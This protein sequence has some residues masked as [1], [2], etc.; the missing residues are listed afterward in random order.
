MVYLIVQNIPELGILSL[1]ENKKN[2]PECHYVLQ[3]V[4]RLFHRKKRSPYAVRPVGAVTHVLLIF[5]GFI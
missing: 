5:C 4:S 2:I 3:V 1:N